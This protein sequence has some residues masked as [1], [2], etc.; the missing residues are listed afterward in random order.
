[1]MWQVWRLG[2]GSAHCSQS[3]VRYPSLAT[4]AV[5]AGE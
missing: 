2:K 3:A 5:R 1:M 4:T